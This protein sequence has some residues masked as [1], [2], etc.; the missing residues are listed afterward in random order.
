[1]LSFLG[2]PQVEHCDSSLHWLSPDRLA[3]SNPQVSMEVHHG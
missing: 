2:D 3:R 1:V